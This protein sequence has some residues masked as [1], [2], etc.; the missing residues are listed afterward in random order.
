MNDGHTHSRT[1]RP[2]LLQ[3]ADSEHYARM[4]EITSPAAR[5]FC[6]YQSIDYTQFIGIKRGKY[7]WQAS[8]N[9]IPMLM[10][11]AKEG[12]HG[13]AIYLDADAYPFDLRFDLNEYLGSHANWAIIGARGHEVLHLPNSGILLINFA[14]DATREIIKAWHKA[15]RRD[16]TD[17]MLAATSDWSQPDDQSLLHVILG[18]RKDTEEVL[19]LESFE[20]M[21]WPKS[22]V[23]R[24]M[25]RQFGN[26]NQRCE[27]LR[28]GV[29]E[30][31]DERPAAARLMAQ[32]N[33]K[34]N[35]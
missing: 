33:E 14:H 11:L 3:T 21:G 32:I 31:F 27:A 20:V 7:P 8:Y 26:F 18:K 2:L 34:E 35:I 23:F 25:L 19:K 17:E 9:R 4:L 13:W 15:F 16:V 22:A 10:E 1:A 5:K 29:Q 30:A 6:Y 24:Q 28:A 12:F